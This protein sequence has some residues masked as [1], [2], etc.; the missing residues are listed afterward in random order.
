VIHRDIKPE[1][2]FIVADGRVKVLDFGLARFDVGPAMED[3]TQAETVDETAAGIV[4]GTPGYMSP[5]QVRGQR[6]DYR[7]DIFSLGCVS[8]EMAAGKRPFRGDTAADTMSAVLN[9]EPQEISDIGVAIPPELDAIILRC[10]EKDTL[11]RYASA[12]DFV[13]DLE[14][15]PEQARVTGPVVLASKRL[16]RRVGLRV[17]RLVTALVI[18]TAV[19]VAG[20]WTYQRF[21]GPAPEQEQVEAAAIRTIAVG[22]FENLTGDEGYDSWEQVLPE[23]VTTVLSESTMLRVGAQGGET[24]GLVTG[25]LVQTSNGFRLQTRVRDEATG[26]YVVSESAEA[27]ADDDLGAV[28]GAVAG[29][30]RD[31][32]ELAVLAE[33]NPLHAWAAASTASPETFKLFAEAMNLHFKADFAPAAAALEEALRIDPEYSAAKIFLFE[34]YSLIGRRE[35]ADRLFN[36][37][38]SQVDR[39]SL[40]ERF[41]VEERACVQEKDPFGAIDYRLKILDLDPEDRMSWLWL[42]Q[43]YTS[44]E[45]YE[46]AIEPYVRFLELQA[47]YGP[48]MKIPQPHYWLADAYLETDQYDRAID[49]AGNGLK[50]SRKNILLN[51]VAH[52]ACLAKGD[53]ERASAYEQQWTNEMLSNVDCGP[54]CVASS[55]GDMHRLYLQDPAGAEA[56][57]RRALE[58]DPGYRGA[59][60]GLARVLIFDDL[61]VGEG[62]NLIGK[63]L[64][65]SPNSMNGRFIQ[66]WGYFKLGDYAKAIEMLESSWEQRQSYDHEHR[67]CL[68]SARNALAGLRQDQAAAA[69]TEG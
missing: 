67:L 3:E 59:I 62:M 7:T 48:E 17:T 49:A 63:F 58:I 1:N 43:H 57:Y 69:A 60:I 65:S 21:T 6:V 27:G 9:Q 32:L 31:H 36:E 4:L 28:A 26:Q 2:I 40:R 20:W 52:A 10:L 13:A 44:A 29:D 56:E 23:L 35:E 54:E 41:L 64:E 18:A 14:S 51:Q 24:Q 37:L 38:H 16:R 5:E 50:L 19:I 39:L 8:Y 42:G 47:R 68:E 15:I 12:E 22:S 66:R 33:D 46:K 61:D 55:L 25:S 11:E 53:L 30:V 34:N 45:Q